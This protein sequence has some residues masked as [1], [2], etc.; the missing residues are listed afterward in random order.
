MRDLIVDEAQQKANLIDWKRE[1][2]TTKIRD[3][4]WEQ[5]RAEGNRS[6]RDDTRR[7]RGQG[8][9]YAGWKQ[10]EFYEQAE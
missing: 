8:D 1:H 10:D 5:K 4:T 3:Q 9:R 6:W 7:S 2:N